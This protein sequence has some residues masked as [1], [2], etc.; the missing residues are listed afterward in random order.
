MLLVALPVS[1]QQRSAASVQVQVQVASRTSL[2]VSSRT[3]EFDL[4]EAGVATIAVDF[5]AGA[6]LSAGDELVLSVEPERAIARP[7]GVADVETSL[8]FEG[9]GA[10]TRAGVIAPHAPAVAARWIGSGVRTGRLTFVLVAA[11]P[12]RYLVPVRFVLST[13]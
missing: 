7:G 12:G 9:D 1:A 4:T 2:T 3:L 13:P 8:V 10:G 6:R 11:T 5:S